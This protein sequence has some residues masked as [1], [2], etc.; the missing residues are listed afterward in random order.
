[1]DSTSLGKVLNEDNETGSK[2]EK[3]EEFI[4][5]RKESSSKK[6][7][8]HSIKLERKK[9]KNPSRR[10]KIL[11]K[12]QAMRKKRGSFQKKKKKR[13]RRKREREREREK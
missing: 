8:I 12:H 1:M 10:D 2:E 9:K 7:I 3:D 11:R 13:R 5:F 4:K 6:G